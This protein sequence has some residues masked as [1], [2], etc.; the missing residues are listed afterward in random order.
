[1]LQLLRYVAVGV[2]LT[3]TTLII[4]LV[5]NA[6]VGGDRLV[7][8]AVAL[9][10]VGGLALALTFTPAPNASESGSWSEFAGVRGDGFNTVGG[11]FFGGRASAGPQSS[12]WNIQAVVNSTLPLLVALG[13]LAYLYIG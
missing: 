1:M 12:D 3:L 4:A 10:V 9:V 6:A 11:G 2:G 5:V 8:A 13:I 7:I